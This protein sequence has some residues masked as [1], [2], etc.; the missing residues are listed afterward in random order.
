MTVRNALDQDGR[1][2]SY[3][4]GGTQ[5]T[6]GYDNASRV[7][8]ISETGNPSNLN[9]YGYDALDRLSSAVLSSVSYGY[10]YDG[11]GNRL[12]KAVGAGTDTYAYPGTSNRLASI[13]PTSGPVRNYTHDAVGSVTDDGRLQ[14]VY[15]VRGRLIQ[16]TN[17][18]AC[19][20]SKFRV[21]ALGQRVR[22]TVTDSHE[23]AS[24]RLARR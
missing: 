7:S 4:L 9:S 12:T 14:H 16:S 2:A 18:A 5:Y 15:D 3:T 20:V 11:V 10:S 17:A 1:V 13:T 8:L 24:L 19:L 22:K 21:S 6:L 23:N